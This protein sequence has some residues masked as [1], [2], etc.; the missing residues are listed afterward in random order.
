MEIIKLFKASPWIKVS[1]CTYIEC[2]TRAFI[3]SRRTFFRAES[4]FTWSC[5]CKIPTHTGVICFV[6][7]VV[8]VHIHFTCATWCGV[9]HP[10]DG[11]SPCCFRNSFT[12][13]VCITCWTCGCHTCNCSWISFC[14]LECCTGDCCDRIGTIECIIRCIDCH[15]VTDL[16]TMCCRCSDGRYITCECNVSNS[17][18]CSITMVTITVVDVA[19]VVCVVIVVEL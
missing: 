5:R 3:I 16:I 17:F 4:A 2:S 10:I 12:W 14:I 11:V 7:I 9:I 15:N 18:I 1:F 6:C 19:C 8:S 13:G